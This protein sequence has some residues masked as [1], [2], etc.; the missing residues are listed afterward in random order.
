MLEKELETFNLK[1][2]ELILQHRNGGFV[3]IKD[4]EILGVW[5]SR[6]DALK[7]GIDKFGNVPFLVKNITESDI[8]VNFTRNLIFT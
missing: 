4:E 5:Q 2:A 6:M 1:K 7:A 8:A 3:V